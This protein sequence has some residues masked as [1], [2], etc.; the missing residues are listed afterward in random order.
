MTGRIEIKGNNAME[1][2]TNELTQ[3]VTACGFVN[4]F[5]LVLLARY[6]WPN[7]DE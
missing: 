1:T 6:Q 4:C 3:N 7:R 5:A 2:A